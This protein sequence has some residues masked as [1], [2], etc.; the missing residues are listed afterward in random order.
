MYAGDNQDHN[1]PNMDGTRQ[2]TVAGK[3]S[4]HPCWVAGVLTLGPAFRPDNT[5]TAM[6]IDHQA[7]PYGAYLG[8]YLG[9]SYNVFKCPA[10]Q[11]IYARFMAKWTRVRSY[12][13]NNFLGHRRVQTV[14][15][16]GGNFES[17]QATAKYPPFL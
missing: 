12:S 9:K 2:P 5:N 15:D 11:S 1:V 14:T 3:D 17:H 6:L 8:N 16:A 7:Y 10:D 4:Q 13:M